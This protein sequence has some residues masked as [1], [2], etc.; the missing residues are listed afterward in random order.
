MSKTSTKPFSGSPGRMTRRFELLTVYKTFEFIVEPSL[1]LISDR[2]LPSFSCPYIGSILTNTSRKKTIVLVLI[3]FNFPI[4]EKNSTDNRYAFRSPLKRTFHG[5]DRE[6][7]L[8]YTLLY[9]YFCC[10]ALILAGKIGAVSALLPAGF[11]TGSLKVEF[12][13]SSGQQVVY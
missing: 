2:E 12:M 10:R 7:N 3:C 8:T 13:A 9:S 6:K 1:K 4:P 5:K 11:S